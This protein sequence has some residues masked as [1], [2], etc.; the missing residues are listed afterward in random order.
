MAVTLLINLNKGQGDFPAC[1]PLLWA[2]GGVQRLSYPGTGLSS[3]ISWEVSITRRHPG[4]VGLASGETRQW[5]S[6]RKAPKSPIP[7]HTWSPCPA[8]PFP[9]TN[10][11]GCNS[12]SHV[13]R[14]TALSPAHSEHHSHQGLL[15][16]PQNNHRSLLGRGNRFSFIELQSPG[17]S[18]NNPGLLSPGRVST[19]GPSPQWQWAQFR[20]KAKSRVGITVSTGPGPRRWGLPERASA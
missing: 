8:P 10:R 12:E 13:H 19:A 9:S 16:C 15:L 1:D 3:T 18:R 7:P 20:I 14:V 5:N 11:R 17:C 2:R 4:F 6:I